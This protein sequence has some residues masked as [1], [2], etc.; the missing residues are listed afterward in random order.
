MDEL[1]NEYLEE[2]LFDPPDIN[3]YMYYM[4]YVYQDETQVTIKVNI[5]SL[6]IFL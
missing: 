1:F 6:I 3:I 5:Y 4:Y 2:H